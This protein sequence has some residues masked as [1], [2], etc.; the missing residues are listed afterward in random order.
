MSRV[1]IWGEPPP[2]KNRASWAPVV[3]ML[4]AR[5]GH[6]A[7]IGETTSSAA[8]NIKQR[9]GVEVTTRTKRDKDGEPVLGRRGQTV[10]QIY[11][12]WPAA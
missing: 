12:R 5:P 8:W 1:I 2:M 9:Y 7:L 6:W 11:A 3:E 4:K 10:L